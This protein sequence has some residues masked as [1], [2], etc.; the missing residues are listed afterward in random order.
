MRKTLREIAG[1]GR[2]RASSVPPWRKYSLRAKC[3]FDP[4]GGMWLFG[5]NLGQTRM[6]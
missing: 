1:S 4:R 3:P 2:W 5:D 6:R